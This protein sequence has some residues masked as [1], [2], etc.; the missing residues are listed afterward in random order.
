MIVANFRYFC[1]MEKYLVYFEYYSEGESGGDKFRFTT[2]KEALDKME[3]YKTAI[4]VN[5]EGCTDAEL[6]DEDDFFGILDHDSGDYA[7]VIL[8][9]F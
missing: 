5:F 3:E 1:T 2:R 6:I 9:E 7:K 8:S 4:K